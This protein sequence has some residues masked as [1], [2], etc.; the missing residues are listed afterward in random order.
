MRD[1]DDL[2]VEPWVNDNYKSAREVRLQNGTVRDMRS[3]AAA[4]RKQK[5]HRIKTAVKLTVASIAIIGTIVLAGKAVLDRPETHPIIVPA[6]YTVIYAPEDIYSDDTVTSIAKEYYNEVYAEMYGSLDKF[7][8]VIKQNNGLNF[9]GDIKS[10]NSLN[11]PVLVDEN[12]EYFIQKAE[13][14]AQIA[15][16]KDPNNNEKPYWVPDYKVKFGDSLLGLAAKA[17]GSTTET[18]Q[19][20]DSIMSKNGL[21]NSNI[22]EGQK[23]IIINP[24]LGPLKIQLNEITEA[25]YQ[26]LKTNQ[27]TK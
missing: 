17:S 2:K 7:I 11:I 4:K 20:I 3:K 23:L 10:G 5:L 19:L 13:L 24:E 9:K 16:Y 26:S 6:G 21:S 1:N 18:Y 14:E 27:H 8:E 15:E 12:N 25:F 22:Y